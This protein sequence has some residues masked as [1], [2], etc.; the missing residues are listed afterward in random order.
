MKKTIRSRRGSSSLAVILCVLLSLVAIMIAASAVLLVAL[1]NDNNSA[2][3]G[4]ENNSASNRDTNNNSRPA[5]SGGVQNNTSNN[6]GN[7]TSGG[8]SGGSSSPLYPT[9]PSRS[10]YVSASDEGTAKLSNEIRS[11]S[12]ILVEL[13]GY[14]AL[15]E[16]NADA[17]V[18]PASMTKVMTLLVVCENITDISKQLT[19]TQEMVDYRQSHD[20]SGTNFAAGEAVTAK[21]F[22]Y[23]VIYDSDTTA[24]LALAQHIAGSEEAFVDMMNRKAESLGLTNTHFAN[25]TGLY[26]ENHYTTC[27]EMAAIMAYAMENEMART[28]LSSYEYY[29][30]TSYNASS[31]EVQKEF[32]AWQ[33]WYSG[34]FS[35]NPRLSKVTVKAGK[36]GY[37]DE[38]GISLVTYAESSDGKAYVNVIVGQPKGGGVSAEISTS[39]VKYIYNNY[40]K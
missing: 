26:D 4:N 38:S 12:T 5:M 14:T 24:C 6:N 23:L 35:D 18:Y 34:R 30:V 7:N 17:R 3:G 25:V 2:P 27:R 15:A 39:E 16:K 21:D 36:T 31:G 37:I 9:T 11:Q 10:N 19:V 28:I 22:M 20:A 8:S 13:D 29:P 33:D 32:G 1:S 40:V